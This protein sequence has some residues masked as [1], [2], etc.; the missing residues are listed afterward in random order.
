[1]DEPQEERR[2]VVGSD[3]G[4]RDDHDLLLGVFKENPGRK[5]GGDERLADAPERLDADAVR[6]G[7]DEMGNVVLGRGWIREIEVL[8]DYPEELPEVLFDGLYALGRLDAL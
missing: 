7:R 5:G 4:G 2:E 8:P 6:S 1:M 3:L